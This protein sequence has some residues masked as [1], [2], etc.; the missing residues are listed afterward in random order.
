MTINELLLQFEVEH[1]CSASLEPIHALFRSSP[2]LA[3]SGHLTLHNHDY[4]R[5]VK[6]QDVN[7]SCSV[8]KHRTMYL[9]QY[10]RFFCGWCPHGLWELVVP[11]PFRGK[12]A[13]ILYLGTLIRPEGLSTA[14]ANY[15][16]EL[17][18]PFTPEKALELKKAAP[19][20]SEFLQRELSLAWQEDTQS[21]KQH[22]ADHYCDIVRQQ[23]LTR[24]SENLTLPQV[25]AICDVTPNYLSN[26]LTSHTGKTF[27]QMLTEQRIAEAEGLLKYHTELTA[28]AI[29]KKCGFK[30]PNYFNV[31]FT[32]NC[33]MTPGAYRK[34]W[35]ASEKERY[36]R[37]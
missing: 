25:A 7:R 8:N 21:R 27:R 2:R 12:T 26:I 6:S 19:F 24:F 1:G 29:A 37:S 18:P 22:L 33:G 17:P 4:C 32:R 34:N 11:V 9:A 13:A 20:L 36:S 10:G 31:V 35:S 14:A 3:V 23:I 16:G 5:F 30:D 15:T 28:A